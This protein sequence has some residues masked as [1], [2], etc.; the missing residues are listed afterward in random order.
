M[1]DLDRLRTLLA[2]DAP[3]NW[4]ITGDSIT[5]GLMHT[6]GVRSY[7]EHLHEIV[8]SERFRVDDVMVNT[9]ISGHRLAQ[10]LDDFD[11]R[12]AMWRPDVVTLM[13]GANDCSTA[14]AFPPIDAGAFGDALVQFVE[15]VRATSAIPV[16][17]TPPSVDVVQAPERAR[18]AEF[19]EAMRVVAAAHE[20]A[21][22]DVHA[23]FTRIGRGGVPT[24]L[25]ND[26]FHP[27]AAGH[28]A[29]AL[30]AA[31]AL[32]LDPAPERARTFG[33]LRARVTEATRLP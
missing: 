32:G 25:M 4:V 24:G 13:I 30:E 15:R 11:R 18:I 5:H 9:A 8:R 12:V 23:A 20:V 33:L 28:A 16:L 7:A 2:A 31:T 10:I 19:A 14:G 6:Q 26:A 21:L 1:N 17:L 29:I 22:V 3:L 27:N